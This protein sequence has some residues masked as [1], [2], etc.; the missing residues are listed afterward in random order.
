ML[1]GA[2]CVKVAPSSS[3]LWWTVSSQQRTNLFTTNFS[4]FRGKGAKTFSFSR[5]CVCVCVWILV[6]S[7]AAGEDLKVD[8]HSLCSPPPVML[9]L[10]ASKNAKPPKF[11]FSV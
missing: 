11:H 2:E 3:V 1:C 10:K 7:M 4:P 8:D 9:S 5:G 6:L